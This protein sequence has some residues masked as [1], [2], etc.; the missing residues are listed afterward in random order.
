ME[1]AGNAQT[2]QAEKL[3]AAERECHALQQRL[4]AMQ[5][6]FWVSGSGFRVQGSGFR[7]QGSGFRVQGSGFRWS[8][9]SLLCNRCACGDASWCS[10]RVAAE[11]IEADAG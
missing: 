6:V 10:Q 8:S 1:V 7:V 11:A 4:A 3:E 9:G 2:R 5:Q